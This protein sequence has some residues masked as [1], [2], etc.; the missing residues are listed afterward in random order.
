METGGD[1]GNNNGNDRDDDEGGNGDGFPEWAVFT[2]DDWVTV[3]VA[4]TAS[5]FLRTFVAEPRFIPSLSMYPTYDIGDR[6]IAEK[7]TYRFNHGPEQGDVIIFHPPAAL[8][9][10]GYSRGDVFIKRI[11]AV[12]GQTVAVHDGRVFVNGKPRVREDYIKDAPKY[13]MKDVYVPPGSVFVMGDNRNNSFDSH[14]WGPLD[15]ESI[16]G[17]VVFNYWPPNKVG[18]LEPHV[19]VDDTSYAVVEVPPVDAPDVS[20]VAS[21]KE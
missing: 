16:E 17:R 4:L 11:V 2:Q 1:S 5:L 21:G 7:I 13:D 8:Q 6:L 14:L 3:G 15:I 9:A 10:Q 20:V 12:G 18:Q 19:P